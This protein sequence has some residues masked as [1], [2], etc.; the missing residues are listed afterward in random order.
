MSSFQLFAVWIL[1]IAPAAYINTKK[2][3]YV[4]GEINRLDVFVITVLSLMG[5]IGVLAGLIMW[6]GEWLF[7]TGN[8]VVYKRKDK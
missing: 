1:C 5:P 8:V 6:G 7:N 2:I 4:T 3:L